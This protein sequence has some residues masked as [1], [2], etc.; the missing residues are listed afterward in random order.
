M[1][2]IDG[3]FDYKKIH[4]LTLRRVINNKNNNKNNNKKT[5]I[6]SELHLQG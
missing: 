5:I 1:N 3:Q 6:I 2:K 4:L